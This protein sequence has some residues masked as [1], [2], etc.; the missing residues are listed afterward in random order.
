M[1]SY[2]ENSCNIT[3]ENPNC[4]KD[5]NIDCSWISSNNLNTEEVLKDYNLTSKSYRDSLS[6]C[7]ATAQTRT[8]DSNVSTFY[9]SIEDDNTKKSWTDTN[10]TSDKDCVLSSNNS[11]I[12]GKDTTDYKKAPG[13]GG[14]AYCNNKDY[15]DWHHYTRWT[16]P[17]SWLD[18][19]SEEITDT[20]PKEGAESFYKGGYGKYCFP[21]NTKEINTS[22]AEEYESNMKNN[23][24]EIDA[25]KSISK[26]EVDK[27]NILTKATNFGNYGWNINTKCF[28]SLK[29]SK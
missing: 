3:E 14:L 22:W 1:T 8:T 6:F 26:T 9:I 7:N 17:G 19:K 24:N 15:G 10:T 27:F 2:D 4:K 25:R 21:T 12:L 28:Y 11:I 20:L 5:E 13:T 29:K 23:K 18:K 16:F